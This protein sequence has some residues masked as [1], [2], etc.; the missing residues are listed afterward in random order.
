MMLNTK[1]IATIQNKVESCLC[2]HRTKR[3][4]TEN[5]SWEISREIKNSGSRKL[6]K[7]RS[8]TSSMYNV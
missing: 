2:V 5:N 8:H 1:M 6:S 3:T 4:I 7:T